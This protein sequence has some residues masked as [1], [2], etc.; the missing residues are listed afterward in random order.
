MLF[1]VLFPGQIEPFVRINRIIIMAK[2][3]KLKNP[4]YYSNGVVGSPLVRG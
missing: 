4:T 2:K 1:S 3:K